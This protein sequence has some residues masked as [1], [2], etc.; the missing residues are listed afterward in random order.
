MLSYFGNSLIFNEIEYFIF[1]NLL[2]ISLFLFYVTF[3]VLLLNSSLLHPAVY[4]SDASL[5]L[6]I[7]FISMIYV[8]VI[9]APG[10]VLFLDLDLLSPSSFQVYVLGFQWS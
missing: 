1:I 3:F 5:E 9:I 4:A 7:T 8:I 10:L 6:F 2:L